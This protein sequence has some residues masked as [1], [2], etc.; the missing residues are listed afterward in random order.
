MG[1]REKDR[2]APGHG[3]LPGDPEGQRG[4]RTSA[5]LDKLGGLGEC[6]LGYGTE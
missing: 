5:P 1:R 4:R 6:G 3:D 2:G